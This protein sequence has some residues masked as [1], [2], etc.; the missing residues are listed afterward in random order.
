[1][2]V[3]QGRHR[4][5]G[6][7]AAISPPGWVLIRMTISK[8]CGYPAPRPCSCVFI[9]TA[10]H[11]N[12]PG[13]K[14]DRLAQSRRYVLHEQPAAVPVHEPQFPQRHLP[15]FASQ[16]A[17]LARG[18]APSQY[19][20]GTAAIVWLSAAVIQAKLRPN[21]SCAISENESQR[22]AGRVQLFAFVASPSCDPVLRMHRMCKSSI[23]CYSAYWSQHSPRPAPTLASETSYSSNS[24]GRQR[25][26][27]SLLLY[28]CRH[29][30]LHSH[31]LFLFAISLRFPCACSYETR[32]L[33]CKNKIVSWEPFYEVQ[34]HPRGERLPSC[35][36]GGAAVSDIFYS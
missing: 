20:D 6:A 16:T 27:S 32:C 15:L 21:S 36:C 31:R 12:V 19:P 3:P 13:G 23:S 14:Q 24:E 9:I 1:M 26:W 2:H 8:R 17:V 22:T 34:L 28:Q 7:R 29:H 10:V 4:T 30:R 25:T 5:S 35:W 11:I 33:N 18:C